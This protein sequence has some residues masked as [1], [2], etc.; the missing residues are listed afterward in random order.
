MKPHAFLLLAGGTLTVSLLIKLYPV[1]LN[2]FYFTVDQGQNAVAVRDILINHHL[3]L[4]GPETSIRGIFAGP[5]WYYFLAIGF[6][7]F[8]GDPRGG[9]V[10]M[11]I[12]NTFTLGFVIWWISRKLNRK[13]ALLAGLG[14]SVFWPFYESS[15]WAFNPFPAVTLALFLI[16][17]LEK[18]LAGDKRS[19]IWALI[20]VFL[21]FNTDLATA[22]A[23]WLFAFIVSLCRTFQRRSSW[24]TFTIL[25]LLPLILVILLNG[26]SA[27]SLGLK[28]LSFQGKSAGLGIF[29]GTNFLTVAAAFANILGSAAV[30][31]LPLAGFAVVLT[32]LWLNRPSWTSYPF[33]RNYLRLTFLLVVAS[34]LFFGLSRGW[35][36]WQTVYL[37]PIAFL[38]L[39]F[40]VYSNSKILVGRLIL[41]AILILQFQYG[42]SRY[43]HYPG[44]SADPSILAN[45]YKVI[46]WIYH[47]AR[48]QGF[49]AYTYTRGYFDYPQQY[50]FWWY[51]LKKYGY[52]PC[53]YA[54]LPR[55][56]KSDYVPSITGFS[57]PRKDCGQDRF[58]IVEDSTNGEK[59]QDW[60]RSYRAVTKL[61]KTV[62]LGGVTIEK[63]GLTQDSNM[64][65]DTNVYLQNFWDGPLH[66]MIPNTWPIDHQGDL[67][68]AK[69]NDDL[70]LKAWRL[71]KDCLAKSEEAASVNLSVA[72]FKGQANDYLVEVYRGGEFTDAVHLANRIL[73]SVAIVEDENTQAVTTCK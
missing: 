37:A 38:G 50:L 36:D 69:Y 8:G 60:I 23:L 65:F 48:D 72:I 43:L 73:K 63:R 15:A 66:L 55:A 52:L 26:P 70:W 54:N 22:A 12:L 31:Q 57:V 64:L 49:G 44:N 18:Y 46:D 42:F 21:S 39:I 9:V 13:T 58:L 59:N 68:F 24:T 51:G 20:I 41:I 10:M 1:L 33:I 45:R 71:R 14:L 7:A 56:A 34:L 17:F 47:Q 3:T 11:I 53:E 16:Y 29:R 40:V 62:K 19:L 2:N 6:L 30:P 4:R 61:E 5:L 67:T 27:I 35:K 32:L 28:S 25:F